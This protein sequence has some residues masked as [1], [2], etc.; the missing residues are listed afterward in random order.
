VSPALEVVDERLH[1][2][3][4]VRLKLPHGP[5]DSFVFA[6][7]IKDETAGWFVSFHPVGSPIARGARSVALGAVGSAP[8]GRGGSTSYARVGQHR[9][10]HV[11]EAAGIGGP[12]QVVSVEPCARRSG[13]LR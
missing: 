13:L 8:R 10:S 3:Q 6:S 7:V 9:H 1:R 11:V 2:R 4:K 5:S 12:W